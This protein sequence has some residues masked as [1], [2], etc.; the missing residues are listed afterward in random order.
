MSR[1]G[2]D[3][4]SETA[5]EEG[6]IARQGSAGDVSWWEREPADVDINRVS[7][8][9]TMEFILAN[10]NGYSDRDQGVALEPW[11]SGDGDLSS[12]HSSAAGGVWSMETRRPF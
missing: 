12:R 3:R 9:D 1:H 4:T 11:E 8:S 6:R 2:A 7:R 10:S 5:E